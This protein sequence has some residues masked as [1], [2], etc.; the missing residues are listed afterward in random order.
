M[1]TFGSRCN[2]SKYCRPNP[3]P[4][5]SVVNSVETSAKKSSTI[6]AVTG[7]SASNASSSREIN[8]DNGRSQVNH[9]SFNS[10]RKNSFGD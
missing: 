9:G 7:S 2:A 3:S 6:R 8:A 5:S 4:V 10:S 1:I